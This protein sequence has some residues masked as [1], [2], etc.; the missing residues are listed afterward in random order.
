MRAVLMASALMVGLGGCIAAPVPVAG[1]GV[2]AAGGAGLAQPAGSPLEVP[3]VAV[4]GPGKTTTAF[5]ADDMACRAARPA[6]GAS[7]GRGTT[8]PPAYPEMAGAGTAQDTPGVG[9]LRCM[10]SRANTVEPIEQPEPLV[11][12]GYE[13]AYPV[14]AGYDYG[15]PIAYDGFFGLGFYAGYGGFYHRGFYGGYGPGGFYRPGFYGYRG[16]YGGFR[17]GY[18]GGFGGRAGFGGG[19]GGFRGDGFRGGGFRD[20][21]GFRGR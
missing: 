3:L 16:G 2:V 21:G 11:V 10:V 18:G 15:F 9:Y 20:G 17:G 6:A 14:Y 4:P 12:Y 5:A 1:P 7:V 13:P 8:Y 19:P